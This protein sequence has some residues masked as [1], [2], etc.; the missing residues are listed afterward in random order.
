[1]SVRC[2]R[3]ALFLCNA[4]FKCIDTRFNFQHKSRHWRV[5]LYR[6]AISFTAFQIRCLTKRVMISENRSSVGV[7]FETVYQ[8]IAPSMAL[9]SIKKFA[10]L[11][12]THSSLQFLWLL[13]LFTPVSMKLRLSFN[14]KQTHTVNIC[15]RATH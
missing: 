3:D 6:F 14:S 1:M 12:G 8:E 11:V 15:K 9:L 13:Y 10:T 4:H 7:S 5:C 2:L